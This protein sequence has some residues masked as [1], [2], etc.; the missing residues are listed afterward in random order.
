MKSDAFDVVIVGG[1]PAG[2]AAA[3]A[4]GRMNRRAVVYQ[5]G[6]PRTAHAPCYHNYLGFPDGISGERLLD[7]GHD[8]AARW[9]ASFRDEA[10]VEGERSGGRGRS[11]FVIRTAEGETATAA[12]IV[13]A[14]GVK[15]CQPSCGAL[16]GETTEGIHYC[17]ICDGRETVGERVAVVGRDRHAVEMVGAL[18][19]FTDDLHLLLDDDEDALD[20]ASAERLRRWRVRV[21]TGCLDECDCQRSRVRFRIRDRGWVEFP[22]VFLALGVVPRT[23]VAESLG[24]DLDDDGYVRTLDDQAT[25]ESFVFAAGDCDGG[26]KQV[27]QAMAEGELAAIGLCKALREEDGPARA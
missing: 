17:V 25:S 9:G 1:G 27:S 16:Y 12:G 4:V 22:H 11:R 26:L 24:C 23:R 3:V 20:E 15:D 14:T 2:L 6:T 19:D 13:L 21:L 7:L 18:R 8:H 10:V 5:A